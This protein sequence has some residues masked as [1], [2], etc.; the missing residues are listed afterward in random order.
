LIEPPGGKREQQQKS[1]HELV[2]DALKKANR[3]LS[4][5]ELEQETGLTRRQ[6]TPV[7]DA[8]VQQKRLVPVGK[9]DTPG[10][11]PKPIL[12]GLPARPQD[13][14]Q[15]GTNYLP[16][17]APIGGG[18]E[19]N[20]SCG[21]VARGGLPAELLAK[22]VQY[23]EQACIFCHQHLYRPCGDGWVCYTCYPEKSETE[24]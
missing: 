7:L 17:Y 23:D 19:V 3:A 5:E 9:A 1:H 20:N 11:G 8:L 22:G 14:Q 24:E 16:I 2:E 13:A 21:N 12:Y 18:E 4:V 6:V 15:G 10:R